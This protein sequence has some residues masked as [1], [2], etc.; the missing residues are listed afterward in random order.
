MEKQNKG[1]GREVC[2]RERELKGEKNV[3]KWQKSEINAK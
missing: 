2:E 1:R 3:M